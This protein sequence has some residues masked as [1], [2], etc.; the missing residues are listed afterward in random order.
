MTS[1]MEKF[2]LTPGCSWWYDFEFVSR[3][4]RMT[5]Q[6]GLSPPTLCSAVNVNLHP[7]SNKPRVTNPSHAFAILNMIG[8][9]RYV[10][11]RPFGRSTNLS[12]NPPSLF[13]PWFWVGRRVGGLGEVR[14]PHSAPIAMTLSLSPDPITIMSR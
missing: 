11:A 4:A 14:Q 6:I 3:F 10:H 2:N 9:G 12:K 1:V 5:L 7:D 13:L 8:R